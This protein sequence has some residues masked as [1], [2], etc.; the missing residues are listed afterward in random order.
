MTK[1]TTQSNEPLPSYRL[2]SGERGAAL[3]LALLILLLLGAISVTVL[4]VVSHEMKI[5]GSD[6][7]RTETYSAA[8]SAI[9]SMTNQ[10]SALFQRTSNPSQ[11][12]LD[13]IAGNLP[14]EL[15]AQG[16]KLTQSM[17]MDTKALT[18]MQLTQGIMDGSYPYVNLEK[19]ALAGLRA[20]V[21][22]YIVS[23]T[24]YN[25]RTGAKVTLE[26]TINNYLIPMF[27]FGTFSDGDL[28]FWP[29]PPM[30]FNGRV[31]A[32]GNIYFGGDITFTSKVTTAN[33]AVRT[34]LR[35]NGTLPT[36][37]SI[38]YPRFVING[39]T[40]QMTKGSVI[41]GPRLAQPRT[42]KRGNFPAD[43]PPGTDNTA[44]NTKSI[45]PVVAGTA[46]QFGG[47]LLTKG[48]GGQPLLL[49]MQLDGK[50][51]REI[52]KRPMPDDSSALVA[53]RFSSKAEIRILIDDETA[54][55]GSSNIAGIGND[56]SGGQKGL[57]LSTFNPSTLDGGKALRQ[58]KDDG[59]GYLNSTDWLQGKPALGLKAE[60][61]RGVRS[62]AVTGTSLN[63]VTG[64]KNANSS[65]EIASNSSVPKSPNGAIIPPGSGITGR[66]L[67]EVRK[68]DGTWLDVTSTIL[69]MG[70]TVGEPN[71]IVYLQRPLWAAYMQGGRDR[72]GDSSHNNYLNYFLDT[73]ATDRRCIADGE[74][75]K[76][77]VFN[78]TGFIYE[79][80]STLD[81]DPHTT[82]SK[83]VPTAGT[84][85]R[86]DQFST[87][88]GSLNKIVPITL[89]NVREGRIDES[90][91]SAVVYERGIVSVIDIN[92]RN[93][94]RWV[95]G[96]FDNNLLAGTSAVSTNIDGSDGYVVYISDRRGDRVKTERNASNLLINT[97]NGLVDNEDVYG[98]N[99]IN[100][101]VPDPGE[102]VIDAGFDPAT[103]K[104]KKG[105]LQID[106]GELPSPAQIAVP[107]NIAAPSGVD[108]TD[109]TRSV[110][111]SEWQL[112]TNTSPFV[113]HPAPTSTTATAPG[114]YFRRAVRVLNG[115]DL[116]LS[117]ATGKLS[118]TK[119]ITVA[120]ENMIFI[121]GNYNTTGING[122]PTGASTSNDPTQTYYFQG[123]Q[124]PSAIVSDAFFPLSKTWYDALPALYPEGSTNRVADAGS[125]TDTTGILPGTETSVRAGIISGT[126][127]SAMVG[128]AAPAYYLQ[129]LN[130]GVHNFPR[131]LETWGDGSSWNKRWNYT[132]SFILLYN[133]TQAVGPYGVISSVIY[134]PPIRNWGFDI[135]FND[136]KKLPPGTPQFQ[137]IEATGFRQVF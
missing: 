115:E 106:L 90:S 54:G 132:G 53:G 50:M 10:F 27:Q 36:V 86:D 105:S 44:W 61:V 94:A 35:N 93:L 135:T 78:S 95:D 38:G 113:G 62:Y 66:I 80:D 12:Q 40:V 101:D 16:F 58:V 137:Y 125:P 102:D 111:V 112:P 5:A 123:D 15:T 85:A 98:Y 32:N 46:D 21:S 39:T 72:K 134:Y 68:P 91:S 17:K 127:R 30:T 71:G 97:T 49:P 47:Q 74:V 92:M 37:Y 128:T 124:V 24:A 129:W 7:R 70:M 84:M 34:I 133:S 103:G 45:A 18:R 2:R 57:R 42:D 31:H 100:G 88:P 119:G 73:T 108:A 43:T 116:K 63:G 75:I 1:Q 136:P 8:A 76:T 130:G 104:D 14:P 96:V 81:D 33:E 51:P 11:T 19:G 87:A 122:Q 23:A 126:T 107:A 55:N 77:P 3:I 6:L 114:Y 89:Y 82:T 67:I 59:T 52:I 4:A 26:R 60:T 110:A 131:F 64:G 83:C 48:T 20:S 117:G 28:E 56:V 22:P 99:R 9:E 13:A 121:W 79:N 120:T 69:S 109:F 65:T 25:S 29:Q 118:A 41:G